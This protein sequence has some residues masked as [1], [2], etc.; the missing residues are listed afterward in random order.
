MLA[1]HQTKDYS[2]PSVG[3][4]AKLL[5]INPELNTAWNYRRNAIQTVLSAGGNPAVAA[6][7]EELALTQRALMKNPKSYATWHHRRWTIKQGFTSLEEEIRLVEKLLDADERNFHGWAYRR[8]IATLMGMPVDRELDYTRHKIEQNFSN[9][10]AWHY[11]TCLLPLAYLNNEDLQTVPSA[12]AHGGPQLQGSTR[13]A[14]IPTSVLNEELEFVKQAFY[15]EPEDQS[16]WIYHRWLLGCTVARYERLR[17]REP[18]AREDLLQTLK[19]QEEMCE[20][21]LS[22]E[23]GSKWPLLTLTRLQELRRQLQG[24]KIWDTVPAYEQLESI[25]PMRQ[26]FYRDAAQGKA[27][28]V[29]FLEH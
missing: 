3:L 29:A 22:I 10:S 6:A 24:V 8:F 4:S 5:E 13:Y 16:G 25:D 18:T 21:L 28:V 23:P 15:T 17:D 20:E 2:P 12:P 9:Y 26:G 7:S 11:R 19:S 1:A 14:G 27:S